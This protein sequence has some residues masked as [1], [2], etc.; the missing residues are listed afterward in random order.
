MFFPYCINEWNNLNLEI[1]DFRSLNIFKTS[2]LSE[3]KRKNLLFP[4]HDPLGAERLTRL[5]LK[6]SHINEHKFR[7]GFNDT[8]SPACACGTEVEITENFLL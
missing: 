4:V 8:I 2:I 3:K 6:F 7:H 5:R 1:R